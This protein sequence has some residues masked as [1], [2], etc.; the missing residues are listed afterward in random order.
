MRSNCWAFNMASSSVWGIVAATS[1]AMEGRR[2]FKNQSMKSGS[3]RFIFHTLHRWHHSR[4]WS[5]RW[6]AMGLQKVVRISTPVSWQMGNWKKVKKTI[7]IGAKVVWAH[8]GNSVY[9]LAT[10]PV[11][12]R[13]NRLCLIK[14]SMILLEEHHKW[15]VVMWL[16]GSLPTFP[17]NLGIFD[18]NSVG[19]ESQVALWRMGSLMRQDK[20]KRLKLVIHSKILVAR[21]PQL[22]GGNYGG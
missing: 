13:W 17:S 22:R 10:I 1:S 11:R 16:E 21:F 20:S 2:D 18:S 15:K 4:I 14:S 3:S 19:M 7:A 6:V 9:H 12:V 5:T 8:N